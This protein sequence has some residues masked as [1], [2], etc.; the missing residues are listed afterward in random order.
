[1]HLVVPCILAPA[2][3]AETLQSTRATSYYRA[4]LLPREKHTYKVGRVCL[5]LKLC[6]AL[7]PGCPHAAPGSAQRRW[8][9][10]QHSGAAM[11]L[12]RTRNRPPAVHT[13]WTNS[14]DSGQRRERSNAGFCL[15]APGS[16]QI[17]TVYCPRDLLSFFIPCPSV[18]ILVDFDMTHSGL[19]EASIINS[20]H[21]WEMVCIFS[22]TAALLAAGH[23]RCQWSH[24]QA[25]GTG[26]DST[27]CST[28]ASQT[29]QH[30]ES[31]CVQAWSVSHSFWCEGGCLF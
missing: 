31:V 14:K 3:F 15:F 4:G 8:A 23:S 5:E 22:E 30:M 17:F 21:N 26:L 27:S 28:E 20:N 18:C 1:M 25:E 24:G 13:D 11:S 29:C 10:G 9:G 16:S 7:E 19:I 6:Y 12:W 2:Q